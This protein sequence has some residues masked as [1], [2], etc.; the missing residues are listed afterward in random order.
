MAE[1]EGM[2]ALMAALT[3]EP[4]PEDARDDA[5]F[6]A[7]HRSALAD[8][9]L[10]REQLRLMGDTLAAETP[11]TEAASSRT[12]SAQTPVAEGGRPEA[13]PSTAPVPL[14]KPKPRR[15]PRPLWKPKSLRAPKPV[16][17]SQPP[18]YRRYAGV[19]LGTL[20]VGAGTALLGGMV[21]LGVQGGADD[22]G[23]ASD[24]AAKQESGAGD[25]S[26]SPEMHLACS[27]V[28]VEGTV[29]SITPTD[30]G[31]VRVVLK[32][33][34]YYRPEQAAVDHP[35]ITVTLLDSARADLKVGTYT[36]IRVPVYPQ[37]RQ[38][39]ETGSGVADARKGIVDALPGARGMECAGPNGG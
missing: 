13:E 39:W 35:T 28:L 38:D 27:K 36:L 26:Y 4:L 17:P 2:D 32:V 25:S 21:W 22:G 9:A 8:V 30:D 29:R 16:R 19:A 31:N 5:E 37:D 6:L 3:D 14:R 24:S 11:G 7:E 12:A 34:R 33:K 15:T 10:L 20:V 23:A 18:W 1:Y